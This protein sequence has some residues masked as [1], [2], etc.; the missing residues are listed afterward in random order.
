M[1]FRKA[2]DCL[3]DPISHADLAESLGVSV[4]LIRQARL[5]EAAKA[6]RSPPDGWEKAV[7]FLAK[8]RI[9]QYQTLI[10]RLG[11]PRKGASCTFST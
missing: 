5:D 6:H 3:F 1:D 2:T 4:P 7:V 11:K 8:R 10:G 9:R